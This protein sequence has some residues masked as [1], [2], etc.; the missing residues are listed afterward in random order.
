MNDKPDNVS[1]GGT[2]LVAVCDFG[3]QLFLNALK[4]LI[5]PLIASSIAL[6]VAPATGPQRAW[7]RS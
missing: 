2:L 1:I 5:V 4:M 6:G 7:L 3:G